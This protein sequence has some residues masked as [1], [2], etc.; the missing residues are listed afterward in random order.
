MR[1]IFIITNEWRRFGAGAALLTSLCLG[2]PAHAGAMQTGGAAQGPE[3]TPSASAA[4]VAAPAA[5]VIEAPKLLQKTEASYPA[6]ALAARLEA[7]VR[8]QLKVDAEGK[9]TEAEVMEPVGHGFDEAARTAALQFRFEPGKRDGVAKR[10][11]IVYTYA[12]RLPVDAAPPGPV[13][14]AGTPPDAALPPEVV[15]STDENTIDVTVVGE[16]AAERHRQSAEAVQVIEMEQIGYETADLGKALARTEGVDVRRAGGLGSNTRVS[17]AGLSD[18]QVRFFVDGI[19]LEFAGYGPGLANVPVNLVQQME[20]YQGVVPIRF[21]AD[22][23]GGAVQLITDQDVHDSGVAA[24]YELGSFDTHRITAS[25]HHLQEST[26][27]LVRAHGFYDNA[28]NDYLV[29]VQVP[30]DA[31]KLAPARLPRFHDGYQAGG[32][33]L[34]VGFVDRPWAQRLL[35]RAFIN[36]TD[37]DIQHNPSMTQVFGDVTGTDGSAGTTLRYAQTFGQGLTVDTVGG[38]TFRRSRFLDVSKCRYDWYGRCFVTL[39]TGGE[40]DS[41][42]VER[43]VNQHAVFARFNASWQ[44]GAPHTLRL[45][46]APTFV[47]RTGEDRQLQLLQQADPLSADRD[48]GSLVTGLE[49]QYEALEG[50]LQNVAFAKDYL[51]STGAQKL[52]ASNE[53]LDLT[54]TTHELGV[55]DSFRL[56]LTPTLTAKASYEWATRLPRPDELFGDGLLIEDNLELVPE[57]S[58]NFNLGLGVSLLP[59]RHGSFRANVGGFARLSDQLIT[60]IPQGS[61]SRYQNVYAARSLGVIGAA[62]WTSPGQLL[63][64]DGNATWQDV[65][66]VSGEGNFGSFKGQRIPNQPSLMANGSAQVKLSDLLRSQD[67]LL[68]TLRSRYVHEFFLAWEGAGAAATKLT[69]DTQLTH[70]VALTYVMR[71]TPTKLSW[72]LDLQNLTN[73]RTFDFYGVQRPGRSLAAKF[74]LER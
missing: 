61:F 23:L 40:M 24:S 43:Y 5:P 60:L 20:V 2:D 59:G 27:L 31:G 48:V 12:F 57:T 8:L 39:E 7:N 37:R 34:E 10:F 42:A 74:T 46:V 63:S 36:A 15:S 18:D 44:P 49:Y 65:R 17:L 25:G 71:D 51:Q 32:A 41:G 19:P 35:V 45:A 22:V 26:G 4:P 11:R 13:A 56:R 62:G 16:S 68:I 73:A 70:S 9:V 54:R 50:R 52:L 47:V 30:N 58:H 69:I 14:E 64:L 67:E 21:S 3:A 55:G 38:Y 1:T 33:S 53:F 29:D 72:T 6:E 66:N 28:R